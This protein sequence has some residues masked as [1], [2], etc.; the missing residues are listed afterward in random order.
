MMD[1]GF[2]CPVCGAG[3][4]DQRPEKR[5][6]QCKRGHSFDFAKEG[7]LYLL[8]PQKKHSRSP[9]DDR[10]MVK[11]RRRF[12]GAGHYAL[13]AEALAKLLKESLSEN[14]A[15]VLLDAGCGEGDDPARGQ[16][17][18]PRARLFGVDIS[19]DAV[20]LASKAVPGARFAVASSFSLPFADAG[21]D[22]LYDVFSPVVPE[23]FARVVKP[24]G[25]FVLAVPAARHLFGLKA[26]LYDHPYENPVQ[27]T[28]YPHFAFLK[29]VPVRGALTLSGAAARDLFAM[30]PY[31]WKTPFSGKERLKACALLKTEIGFDFLCYR[32]TDS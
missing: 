29:R 28:S 1:F 31:A 11:A 12:L 9:G 26:L 24:G 6:A 8:Q 4:V 27:D 10:E 20:R 32:R 16:R 7:Y 14:P 5:C 22:A 25:L 3:L 18:L 21:A 13:F 2:S 17:A 30:T 19:K 15:P 23:E